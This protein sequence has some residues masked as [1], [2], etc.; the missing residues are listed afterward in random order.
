MVDVVVRAIKEEELQEL[1]DL[2]ITV[3]TSC[4]NRFFYSDDIS[5]VHDAFHHRHILGAFVEKN[6]VGYG[7]LDAP[8]EKLPQYVEYVDLSEAPVGTIGVLDDCAVHPQYTGRGIQQR[9]VRERIRL[10][11]ELGCMHLF[12]C[13]HPENFV[14]IHNLQKSGFKLKNTSEVGPVTPCSYYYLQCY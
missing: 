7:I 8:Q 5:Y 9:L 4:D 6:L 14:S 13:I 1:H 12:A 10:A 11:R 2:T 3:A